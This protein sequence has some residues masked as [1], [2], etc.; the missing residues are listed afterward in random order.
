MLNLLTKIVTAPFAALGA[1]FGGGEEMQFVDFDAGSAQL[2]AAQAENLNKLAKAL[3]ERPA[4]EAQ[5]AADR[6][7]GAG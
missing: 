2:P 6:R 7:L 1:L 3:V 4:V 5:R